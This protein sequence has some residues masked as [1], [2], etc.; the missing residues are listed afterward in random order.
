M[1]PRAL[2]Y[3]LSQKGVGREIHESMLDAIDVE[4]SGGT[5]CQKA[6]LAF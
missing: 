1:A 4:A 2:R 5:S 6:D 3:E